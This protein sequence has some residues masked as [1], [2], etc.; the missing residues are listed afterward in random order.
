[1]TLALRRRALFGAATLLAAPAIAR[2]ELPIL[3]IGNQKGGLRSLIDVS[4]E[5]RDLPYRIEWSEF[6]AAAPL[7]EALNAGAIDL[8]SQGDL[9]FLSVYANGAPI[10]AIGATRHNPASQAILVRGDS[11]I[12]TIAD[13]R[14]RK[15]VGN[16]G[17]WGQYLVRAALKRDNIAPGEVT[18]VPLGPADGSLA[19]RSGAVDA[20]AIWEPY[21]S[22]EVEGFGARVLADGTGLTPTVN[23]I[24]VNEKVI[25]EK[26]PLLQDFLRRNQRGW[27]WARGNIPA[28]ARSTS[29][30]TRIPEPMLRRAYEV[31]QSRAVPIDAALVAELQQA[32][33]Q[34]VEFG[35]FSRPIRVAEAFDTS[36]ALPEG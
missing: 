32:S 21:I 30:L 1:M 3:R 4:G 34:A 5:G 36:F 12:R 14:G 31:Q 24:S 10:R 28:F 22:I 27:N 8:G 35:V 33:D 11:P 18:I 20:W 17:G 13:L 7:L 6:P 15:V 9:A 29:E 26:R 25:R 23:F 16:R 2:G 19:F